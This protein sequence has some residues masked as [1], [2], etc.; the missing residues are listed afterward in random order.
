MQQINTNEYTRI[1][2]ESATLVDHMVTNC[3]DKVKSSGV[4]HNGLS[5]HSMSY[6][7]GKVIKICQTQ[8][9]SISLSG[10]QRV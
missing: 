3:P 9:Q 7:V 1:T 6:L 10:N 5:D 4:I 8:I 2:N